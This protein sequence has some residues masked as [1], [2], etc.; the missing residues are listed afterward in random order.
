MTSQAASLPVACHQVGVRYG[1]TQALDQASF[2]VEPGQV[3]ALLGRNGS[4]K[5]SLVRCLLGHQKPTAG[6][7]DLFGQDVWS[8]RQALMHR[9][10]VV[11]EEPDAPP[12]MST[13]QLVRFCGSLY[14]TWDQAGVDQRLGR[15]RIPMDLPFGRLSRGQKGQVSLALAL[16]PKP[17]LLV[18]DDPTLGLDAVARREVYDELLGELGERGTTV[19]IT[20]HDL[21]GIEGLADRIGILHQG[22]LLV[23][24]SLEDLKAR[25]RKVSWAP[26]QAVDPADLVPFA[27]L[28]SRAGSL[29]GEAILTQGDPS[30]VPGLQVHPLSL[31][32][33][34]V[35]LVGEAEV[36]S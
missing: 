14:P 3:Y 8:A 17:S 23:D 1:R 26:T 12:I 34:F 24:A 19:L 29:G 36:A 11:A 18:L 6:R 30:Q 9:V 20:T 25:H 10:G 31:E 35:A 2:Q 21:A 27:P 13:R 15:F 28:W 22:R 4:G 7:V 16:G 33:L 5:T 32:E